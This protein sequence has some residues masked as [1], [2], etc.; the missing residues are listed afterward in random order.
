MSVLDA[1][2]V[3]FLELPGFRMAYGTWGDPA[4]SRSVVLI[5]GITSSS[6]SW[7]RVGPRLAGS[8][9][10]GGVGERYV[11]AVDLK[12]HGDSGRP[13][14]GYRFADQAHEVAEAI[15]RLGL[16]NVSLIGHSWGGA[17]A[18]QL[19]TS[20]EATLQRLVLEDPALGFRSARP[21][22]D[23]EAHAARVR[24]V[25]GYATSVGLSREEAEAR[26][27]LSATAGWTEVDVAG[28]V[29]AMVKGS[30]DAVRAVFRENATWD[31]IDLLAKLTCP[32]LLVR[33]PQANGGIV[34]DA[35]LAVA[36]SNPLI[37]VVTVA[38]ADHNVHRGQFDAFMA[39]V[40]PF[41]D[42]A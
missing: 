8:H 22:S 10:A 5:H 6:L 1:A 29:D 19:A 18:V 3:G 35:A 11:V 2:P 7:A 17:V 32:T 4:A 39:A 21:V 33:A 24:A 14:S 38:D 37:Q 27:R 36:A 40:E 25:E 42:A 26:S 34:D 30:H 15:T 13:A 20:G 41:L 12:G 16:R 28:R 31:V 9:R 23:A